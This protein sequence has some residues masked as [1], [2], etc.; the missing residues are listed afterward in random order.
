MTCGNLKHKFLC[1][2][3]SQSFK[4]IFFSEVSDRAS[5]NCLLGLHNRH[6]VLEN[7]I[8]SV[9]W[10]WTIKIKW[11]KNC[12]RWKFISTEIIF[13]WRSWKGNYPVRNLSTSASVQKWKI[14]LKWFL[15]KINTTKHQRKSALT[16]NLSKQ[17]LF[18][19]WKTFL[20]WLLTFFYFFVVDLTLSAHFS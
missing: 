1:V 9:G 10:H 13:T 4:K 15:L 11:K 20:F 17:N 8:E 3:L 12:E 14:S 7:K 16:D 2:S 18:S 6:S 19:Q 5:M